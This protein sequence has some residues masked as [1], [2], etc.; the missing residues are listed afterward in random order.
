MTNP[1][2]EILNL[3]T[4]PPK[5]KSRMKLFYEST[6]DFFNNLFSSQRNTRQEEEAPE[7][8]ETGGV[9]VAPEADAAAEIEIG[10]H[11]VCLSWNMLGKVTQVDRDPETGEVKGYF[12]YSEW[13]ES[14]FRIAP[15]DIV[16]QENYPLADLPQP[17]HPGNI[18]F[19]RKIGVVQVNHVIDRNGWDVQIS[20]YHLG[21]GEYVNAG[22]A[23]G[24]FIANNYL[25]YFTRRYGV[26]TKGSAYEL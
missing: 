23:D 15:W 7:E 8:N 14:Y 26:L 5:K 22:Y 11:I 4:P 6:A 21:G 20:G 2:L 12:A 10:D 13:N 19:V 16:L 24:Q 17:I 18:V 25:E 9:A 1:L 3:L